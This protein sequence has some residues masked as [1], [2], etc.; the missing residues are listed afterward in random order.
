MELPIGERFTAFNDDLTPMRYLS[1]E[2]VP[3]LELLSNSDHL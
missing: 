3:T 1:V 2:L